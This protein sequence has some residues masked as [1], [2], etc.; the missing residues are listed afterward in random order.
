LN[1][2]SIRV[3]NAYVN[4][5]LHCDRNLDL[6]ERHCRQMIDAG[7]QDARTLQLYSTIMILRDRNEDS[8][9]WGTFCWTGLKCSVATG[10]MP[11]PHSPKA[12][13]YRMA[14]SLPRRFLPQP[15]RAGA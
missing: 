5:L 1:K 15:T 12:W 13:S 10:S 7:R 6:A 3:N 9:R 11:S 2:D 14:R 8:I 4:S